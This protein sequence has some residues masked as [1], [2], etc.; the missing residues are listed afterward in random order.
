MAFCRILLRSIASSVSRNK[1]MS[2]LSL[3]DDFVNNG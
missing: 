1:I 3:S 2:K